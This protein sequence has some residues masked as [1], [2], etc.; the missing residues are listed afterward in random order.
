MGFKTSLLI[1][2]AVS[3]ALLFLFGSCIR[4]KPI[5]IPSPI[6]PEPSS[7]KLVFAYF[8]VW[9]D[10]PDG[11]HAGALTNS[12]VVNASYKDVNWFKK[13]FS[14]MN[15]AGIDNALIV[16]WGEREPGTKTALKNIALALNEMQDA[17]R[18]AMFF[19]TGAIGQWPS[20]ERDLT[21]LSNSQKVYSNIREFFDAIPRKN[22][23]RINGR[24]VISFWGPWFGISHDQSFVNY[25]YVNFEKDYGVKPYLILEE[26]WRFA[27]SRDIFGNVKVHFDV[28][29][30]FD[31]HYIWTP[32]LRNMSQN[33]GVFSITPGYDETMLG[34]TP[35]RVGRKLERDSGNLYKSQWE[36]AIA[37]GKKIV[38]IETWNEY[39]EATQVAESKEYGRQYIELTREYVDKFS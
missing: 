20:G 29:V 12:P 9:Y 17:P 6:V 26:G 19:D 2:L 23:A 32:A 38:F 25:I 35:D 15:E 21:K 1:A 33:G 5:I 4:E 7:E 37:S 24:P 30:T 14:D 31:D 13:E 34:G 11:D 3:F 36:S 28:P 16:F 8:F 27:G 18:I 10:L 22:W 39:H